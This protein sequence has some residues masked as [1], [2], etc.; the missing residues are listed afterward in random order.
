MHIQ[1]HTHSKQE[2]SVNSEPFVFVCLCTCLARG[3]NFHLTTPK[4]CTR[5]NKTLRRCREMHCGWSKINNIRIF[6]VAF[7]FATSKFYMLY[8]ILPWKWIFF[9]F[10]RIFPKATNEREKQPN[11]FKFHWIEYAKKNPG[12]ETCRIKKNSTINE[13]KK[14]APLCAT[15]M[16]NINANELNP[17][18]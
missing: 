5:A 15:M 11:R 3:F 17:L 2:S 6:L 9:L 16:W 10:N 1:T 14:W 12:L 8:I 4:C 7:L 18:E 13:H